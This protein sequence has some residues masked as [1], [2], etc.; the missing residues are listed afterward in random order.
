MQ[1][2]EIKGNPIKCSIKTRDNRKMQQMR[3]TKIQPQETVMNM[4]DID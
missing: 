3:G 2:E 1:R 4:I